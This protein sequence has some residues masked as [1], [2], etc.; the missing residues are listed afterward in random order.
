MKRV[1]IT[2]VSQ[3]AKV[4]KSTVSQFLNKR[5][6]YMSE[7]TKQRIEFAIEDL[8]YQTNFLARSL[9][10][11]RT[12]TIGVIVA[13]IL[14]T[15][16]T[17]VIRSIEDICNQT[18]R[19]VIVCNADDDPEK[20]RKYIEMLRGKQVDGIII[21]PTG[22]NLD[23]YEKMVKEK[24]PLI[25]MDRLVPG[26]SVDTFLL[27]NEEA[28]HL[29]VSHFVSKGHERIGIITTSLTRQVASRVERVAG[30]KK[31][32]E[33][34]GLKVNDGYIQGLPVQEIEQGMKDMLALKEPPTAILAANDLSLM[35]ILKYTHK[36][37][38]KIPDDL[39]VIG[40]DDVSFAS[41]YTP[42]L[43]TIA[44]PSFEMGAQA[45]RLLLKKID[46]KAEVMETPA[47]HRF[48]GQ[49]IERGSC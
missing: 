33:V 9:K 14:H 5:F 40:I 21:F 43:T 2:D 42:S 18:D 20:E 37:G 35:E 30:F 11:K 1:T 28:T 39:A 24:F 44:Q 47:P 26:L 27:N 6:E 19:H 38:I 49:L 3:K 4:S 46:S 48:S 17:Q 45:A 16:S 13:N 22:G 41:F 36:M 31:A 15:F 12:L 7:K 32:C 34:Y 29:A 10:Q 25:F 8:G 23:L